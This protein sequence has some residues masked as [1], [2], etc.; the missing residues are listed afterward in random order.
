LKVLR[1]I[2][3]PKREVL[4]GG[5]RKLCNEELHNLY[6]SLNIIKVIKL[7]MRWAGHI[8]H[9]E[10][11]KNSYRCGSENLKEKTLGKCSYR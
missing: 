10:E 1:R 8:A 9:M 6:F 5:W 7:R 11:M 4:T 2:F 3:E